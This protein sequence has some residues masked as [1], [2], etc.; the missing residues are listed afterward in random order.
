MRTCFPLRSVNRARAV[1]AIVILSLTACVDAP[2]APALEAIKPRKDA[3]CV[4]RDE[5]GVI[6]LMQQPDETG[7]CGYGFDLLV[8][9]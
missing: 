6:L 5:N 2:S 4:Q 8:W 1:A 3:V 7:G 9:G